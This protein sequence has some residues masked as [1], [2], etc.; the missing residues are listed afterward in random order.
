MKAIQTSQPARNTINA[1]HWVVIAFVA[2][3]G[4]TGIMSGYFEIC[5]GNVP[6]GGFQ[7]STIGPAYSMWQH[8]TY[9]A[10]TIIPNF[11]LSGILAIAVSLLVIAWAIFFIRKKYGVIVFILLSALQLFVGG[12]IVI[13]LAIITGIVA[14]QIDKPLTWW[15]VHLSE[16]M[17]GILAGL[18]P[19][20]IVAYALSALLLL[21]AS[22]AGVNNSAMMDWIMVD[23][24]I[25]FA[26]IVLS[27]AGAFARDIRRQNP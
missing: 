16:R 3:C 14:S 5:Q 15:R 13:D 6:T 1:T 19:W 11:L 12:G 4:L 20:A 21:A 27:I 9:N 2:L 22:I 25:M 26:P 18:W 10:V 24:A 23:A 8:S 7:I 17:Q